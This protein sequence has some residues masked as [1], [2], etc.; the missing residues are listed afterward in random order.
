MKAAFVSND[1]RALAPHFGGCRSALILQL[2][3]DRSIAG[4]EFR[5]ASNEPG[6]PTHHHPLIPLLTDCSLLFCAGIGL[7]AA[8]ALVA[9]GVRPV[10]VADATLAP[11]DILQQFLAGTLRMA[12][13]HACCH[14]HEDAHA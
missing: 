3:A 4:T 12:Q 7:P 8:R 1:G 11:A 13:A 9:E 6:T 2:N 14:H 5:R 10:I